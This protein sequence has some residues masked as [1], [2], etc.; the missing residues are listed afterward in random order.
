MTIKDRSDRVSLNQLYLSLFPNKK[1]VK[2]LRSLSESGMQSSYLSTSS[3]SSNKSHFGGKQIYAEILMKILR[4]R[5]ISWF[6]LR[7]FKRVVVSV[8]LNS[9]LTV[10]LG[11][12]M[13]KKSTKLLASLGKYLHYGKNDIG[14]EITTKEQTRFF[15]TADYR[16][17]CQLI[18]NFGSTQISKSQ[19]KRQISMQQYQL[20]I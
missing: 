2:R 17:I 7:M 12:L 18:G 1:K 4:Q 15:K 5:S 13:L 19:S 14:I 20:F 10:I 11:M 16:Q 9:E 6:L 3:Q 8:K